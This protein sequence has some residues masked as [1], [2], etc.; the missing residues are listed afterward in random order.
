MSN[1]GFYPVTKSV[2]AVLTKGWQCLVSTD[3]VPG[4]QALARD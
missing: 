1:R 3:A 2:R 4:A